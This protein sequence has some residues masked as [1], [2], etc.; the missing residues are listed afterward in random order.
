MTRSHLKVLIPRACTH[1]FFSCMTRIHHTVTP[2]RF[3]T[4]RSLT[5]EIFSRASILQL[6]KINENFTLSSSRIR[7]LSSL[8]CTMLTSE[9]ADPFLIFSTWALMLEISL[10]NDSS[11]RLPIL[12][13]NALT[14]ASLFC[15]ASNY[16]F[17]FICLTNS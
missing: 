17:V 2:F 15:F 12:S 4:S 8:Y 1:G 6:P 16:D 13:T 3:L 7:P 5:K 11:L 9:T 10:F 14:I